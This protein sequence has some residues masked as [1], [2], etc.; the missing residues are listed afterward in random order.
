VGAVARAKE[1]AAAAA[2]AVV[3][4]ATGPVV[5]P[6]PSGKLVQQQPAAPGVTPGKVAI[7][8]LNLPGAVG[9]FK[10]VNEK[11]VTRSVVTH[12]ATSPLPPTHS[13]DL[14]ISLDLA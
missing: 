1:T 2:A 10:F 4:G 6:G 8:L 12:G 5:G 7:R 9:D 11:T 13:L 3:G 14:V